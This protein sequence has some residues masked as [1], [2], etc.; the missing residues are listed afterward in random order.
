MD[1]GDPGH[2]I[3]NGNGIVFG[4]VTRSTKELVAS[5]AAILAGVDEEIIRLKQTLGEEVVQEHAKL[6]DHQALV[7]RERA[8]GSGAPCARHTEASLDKDIMRRFKQAIKVSWGDGL[9]EFK[10]RES[11][12]VPGAVRVKSRGTKG[13]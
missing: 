11:T 7:K 13:T 9:F 10:A 2:L 8:C 6:Q 12:T 5:T 4:A 1:E 3:F